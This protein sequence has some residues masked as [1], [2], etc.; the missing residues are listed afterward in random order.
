[1]KTP[2][3]L[4]LSIAIHGLALGAVFLF[5]FKSSKPQQVVEF[6]IQSAPMATSFKQNKN[7]GTG[8]SSAQTAVA[9]NNSGKGKK[10][11]LKGT[12]L[13][14]Q[15]Y[16]FNQADTGS[17]SGDAA[18]PTTDFTDRQNYIFDAGS[19]LADA[20]QWEFYRQVFERIDSQLVFDS[21]LAQ[22]NHFGNVFV[23]FEVDARGRFV[24]HRLK[25]SSD[26]S[27]LKVHSM[28]ALR[29]G[30]K[31]PFRKEKWNPSGKNAI[32]Q[33]HFEFL[34]GDTAINFKKQKEF[35]KAIFVFK[36]A[37]I[38]RP[39]TNDIVDTVV[40][41]ETIINPYL[42][43]ERLEKYNKKKRLKAGEYDPFASYRNDPDY[44]L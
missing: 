16:S 17:G 31:E 34:H 20:D 18:A 11:S 8:K 25:I 43:G 41:K 27:V 39:I 19:M 42:I 14:G 15:Q 13:F 28:R 24:D 3:W 5:E 38:E 37:T 2:K 44:N 23:E 26:D 10:V 12:D 35:G 1:M 30:L 29:K 21:I 33:A 6:E 40:S 7:H 22:Y 4:G 32:L 9:N 36:R